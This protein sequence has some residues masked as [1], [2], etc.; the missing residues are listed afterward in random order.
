MLTL[1]VATK[2]AVASVASTE[3]TQSRRWS[4]AMKTLACEVSASVGAGL[5]VIAL[6]VFAGTDWTSE[7]SAPASLKTLL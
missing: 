7:Y 2:S 5:S 3:R 1:A 6:V 4:T